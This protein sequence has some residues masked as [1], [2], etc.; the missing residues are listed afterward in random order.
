MTHHPRQIRRYA[1]SRCAPKRAHNARRDEPARVAPNAGWVAPLTLADALRCCLPLARPITGLAL[2]PAYR[3]FGDLGDADAQVLGDAQAP[4][5]LESPTMK[6]Q[7]T[8]LNRWR[9][10]DPQILDVEGR[11]H[12]KSPTAVATNPACD[13]H[14]LDR[15]DASQWRASARALSLRVGRPRTS[16]C[17]GTR[18]SRPLK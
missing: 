16:I 6:S 3:R 12:P 7:V 9:N 1:L 4:S 17:R 14:T 8:E 15:T 11:A 13:Q 5:R 10:R 18:I 2:S